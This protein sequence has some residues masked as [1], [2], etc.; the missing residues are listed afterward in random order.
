MPVIWCPRP[1]C[2]R[3]FYSHSQLQRHLTEICGRPADE[4]PPP[5]LEPHYLSAGVPGLPQ[6][7]GPLWKT[8]TMTETDFRAALEQKGTFLLKGPNAARERVSLRFVGQD[9]A[10]TVAMQETKVPYKIWTTGKI[11]FRT[12][13]YTYTLGVRPDGETLS[14]SWSTIGKKG[15]GRGRLGNTTGMYLVAESREEAGDVP[16]VGGFDIDDLGSAGGPADSTEAQLSG[17]GPSLAQPDHASAGSAAPAAPPEIPLRP[18]PP[19]HVCS[20]CFRSP[21]ECADEWLG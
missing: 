12:S 11:S 16:D 2:G 5:N 10:I 13:E 14:Y 21:C 17:Q 9:V 7:K 8:T 19:Y 15:Q 6:H 1:H 3:Y 20:V 18:R 4:V